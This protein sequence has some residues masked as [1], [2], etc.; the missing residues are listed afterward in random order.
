[1]MV[2]VKRLARLTIQ[3]FC[4]DNDFTVLVE[5]VAD[6]EF[7][8]TLQRVAGYCAVYEKPFYSIKGLGETPEIAMS[9]LAEH[10]SGK[11]IYRSDPSALEYIRKWGK[12]ETTIDVPE[13][14]MDPKW[15]L[16]I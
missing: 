3:K 7:E 9:R 8:A 5:E 14:R 15:R 1:M 11:T 12:P 4:E 6:N 16:E 2:L 10:L 13:L